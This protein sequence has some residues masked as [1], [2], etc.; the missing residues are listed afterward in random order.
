MFVAHGGG[1]LPVLGDPGHREMVEHLANIASTVEKPSGIVV[2]SAHWEETVATVTAHPKPPILYDYYGFPKEAYSLAYPAPGD[3]EL[4]ARLVD[5]LAEADIAARLDQER[6]FDHGLYIPLLL[7]YP[8]AD[9]PCVQL[10]LLSSLVPEEHI[11][12]GNALSNLARDNILVLGSG[13][14]FHNLKVLLG[15]NSIAPDPENEAFEAWLVDT[16][17][18]QS[19]GET[20]R[21][22][23][24]TN[25]ESAPAARYCHPRE[26]HLLP[27]HVCY[28]V[29]MRASSGH[30]ELTI[31]GKKSSTYFW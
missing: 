1:P 30:A 25:W 15:R 8:E 11:R 23:R 5:S 20:T 12:I 18:S 17:T 3:P 6:G 10:S 9:I 2:I 16:C 29:R 26:E 28:G 13:F 19:I 22:N 24:L 14:S 4:A 27:L 31:M 21:A 7:M